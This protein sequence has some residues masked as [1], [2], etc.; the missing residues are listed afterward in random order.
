[1]S[2][3][4]VRVLIAGVTAVLLVAAAGSARAATV[5]WD[6]GTSDILTI[7]DGASQGGAGTWNTT[8]L[9]W[10]KAAAP[11]V[12]WVNANNDTAVFGGTA[13]T[14]TLA[15]PIAVGGVAFNV[16][17]YTISGDTLTFG[18]AGTIATNAD[19]TISSAIAGAVAIAKTGAGTLTLSG[20]NTFSGQLSVQGGTLAVGTIN[21]AGAAGTLGNSALP[22]ILGNTGGQTGAL[23][24][25]G[26][27]VSSSKN[28]TMATGGTG[29]FD[30]DNS[31]TNLTLTGTIDG[32][33]G[34]K[35]TGAG[36]LILS[37]TNS[38][39]GATSIAAGMLTINNSSTFTNTS[40]ITLNGTGRLNV[41]VAS[42][43]LAKVA[44]GGGVPAGTFLRYSQPQTSGGTGPG[45]ILGTVELNVTNVNPNYTLDFGDGGTLTNLGAYTYN[46]P[47][48]VSGN[49]F[50]VAGANIFTGGTAMTVSTSTAGLKTLTLTGTNTGANTIGGVISNGSGTLGVAKTGVGTWVLSGTNTYT[51]AT[52]ISTGTLT[53]SN[54]STFTNTSQIALSGTGRLDVNVANQTLAK[55]VT[56]GGVPA[57]TFLRYSQTQTTGNTGPGTIL[58]TVELNVNNVN[59]NYTLD[60][61]T[62]G[63]LT[64]LGAYTYTSPISLSGNASIDSSTAVFT[65]SVGGISASSAGAKTLALTGSNTSANAISS[66]IFNGG[67]TIGVTKSGAGTWILSGANTYTGP[68]N[69]N[70][71]TLTISNAATFT[72]TS[73][74]ALSGTGRLDVGV[75]NQSL[76][77]LVTGGGVPAGASLRYSQ[78]QTTGG[79]GPGTILGTVELNANNVNPNYTL[80]FGAGSTLTCVVTASYTSPITLS[81]NA[82]IDA[83]A[84][85][86]LGTG[87]T[88]SSSTPGA[89]TLTL[90]GSNTGA[91][92]VG[93]V[94]SNGS[95][96]LAV[97]KTGAGSWLLSGANTYTGATIITAGALRTTDGV[98]LPAN[99]P[100]ILNGGVLET[101]G[102][103]ARTTGTG[104]NQIQ[105][106]A[107]GGFSAYGGPLTV[108]LN[109]GT[110]K[111]DWSA[112]MAAGGLNAETLIFGSTATDNVV[113]VPNDL[114]LKGDRTIT[115][116]DNAGATADY[117][118]FSGVLANGDSNPRNLT[119]GGTGTLVL[120]G[121]N[122]Y[123]GSTTIDAGVLTA[124]VL[125]N[126]G[127]VGN[128]GQSGNAAG[129][130]LIGNGAT[131]RYAGAATSTDRLFTINGTAAGHRATI[132]ASGAGP[133]SFT[134][135]GSLEYGTPNQSRT[136]VLA[137]TNTG[138]NTFTPLIT[139][140]GS[141][142]TS[143]TK[144]GTGTWIL[145]VANTYT[146][147]TTISGGTLLVSSLANA[148]SNSNIGAYP[149]A[150]ATGLV[151]GGGTL[152]YTGGTVT[153]NRGFT[154]NAAASTIDV[155]AAGTALTLGACAL[156]AYQFNVTGGSG[157]SLA[158]G[159]VTLT[160]AATLNPTTANLTVASITGAYNLTL[161][162]T[163]AGSTVSGAIT[164]GTAAITKNDAGIWT[165]SGANTYTGVTT[166]S[167]GTLSVASLADAGSASSIG[168]YG[169]AGAAGLVL[170]GGTLKYTGGSATSNRGFTLNTAASTIDVNAVDT[171]LTLG[172]CSLGAFQLN[173]TGGSGS[174]LALGAVTLTGA[175]TLSPT[176]ANLTVG[177]VTGTYNL[178]LRGTSA[179]STVSGAI[180]TGTGTLIKN[181][182]GTWI[183]SGANTYT[184]VTTVSAGTLSV[185]SLG[186]AG[187]AS[188]IGSYGTAGAAG[189]VLGGGTLKYTGS[190]ATI[191]RGFTLNTAAST[192]DVNGADTLLTLGACSLGAFQLNVTGGSGSS[193]A[194]G[195]TTVTGNAAFAP[196]VP[197]VLASLAGSNQTVTFG[198][199]STT[200]VTDAVTFSDS[201]TITSNGTLS[202]STVNITATAAK[203][204]ALR[205]AGTAS[206]SGWIG[207]DGAN[208]LAI[209]KSDPGTWTLAGANAYTG[210][211]TI[212]EGT[213]KIENNTAL[214]STAGGVTV[215]GGAALALQNDIAVDAEALTLNGTG[216]ASGGALR[217]I[218]G[219]NTY[220][221]AITLGSAARINSD[222]GT[223]TLDVAF[224]NAI[225]GTQDL[226]F[227]GA[228]NIA[229]ADPVATG[230]GT[231]TKDGAGTLTL[232]GNN[233]YTGTTTVTAG[234]LMLAPA[235]GSALLAT[236]TVQNNDTLEIAAPEQ[237]A[238]K[239]SGTGITLVDAGMSLTADSIVQ[240]TLT[241]GAGASVTIRATPAA[242]GSANA[243]PEPGTWALIGIGL[244]SLLALGRRRGTESLVGAGILLWIAAR[245]WPP[246]WRARRTPCD[247]G[248]PRRR[249]R[250]GRRA[251]GM[252]GQPVRGTIGPVAETMNFVAHSG[253]TGFFLR[254]QSKDRATDERSPVAPTTPAGCVLRPPAESACG[255]WFRPGADSLRQRGPVPGLRAGEKRH[256]ERPSTRV[257]SPG[258]EVRVRSYAALTSESPASPDRSAQFMQ[259]RPRQRAAGQAG[260][261]SPDCPRPPDV[262]NHPLPPRDEPWRQESEP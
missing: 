67:G 15:V 6:G 201:A 160:G 25:T 219:N 190:T 3:F 176:T 251:G 9:N 41:N 235:F 21:N 111:I 186:D 26:A 20:A 130:L 205:G 49:A 127:A 74:I 139:D 42:Q 94:I 60:L 79:T 233:T 261:A 131:L 113:T 72:N 204:L 225:A 210:A 119:K 182:A 241:I 207:Q 68:T 80:D 46:S 138:D 37:G 262:G 14:V 167:A 226:T 62:G 231:L 28:F 5:Y 56:G 120:S 246:S 208:A 239:I 123:S 179:G 52:N 255:S 253:L 222:G 103:F 133:M 82:S 122:T 117:A 55:L 70:A 104:S 249:C 109:G 157:S 260:W 244:L 134:N 189:L 256:F 177:S 16:A 11:H 180:T 66:V 162:G 236:A 234:T 146:G 194:L 76:A 147:A 85:I 132:D 22:V 199:T 242:A 57:G 171:A 59:P 257:R 78:P 158:L 23:Q 187:F 216:I 81:G 129:N 4:R 227:G 29:A 203:T 173:V 166:V 170:G 250:D 63:T 148:G 1:M 247:P 124:T 24:Y 142:A 118:V 54:A 181:D 92:T 8:I 44:A 259:W 163:S 88:V 185:S 98:G 174:S 47:I 36:T 13:G 213:L 90:T 53:V 220:A 91:N 35:K 73:Q 30:V 211:T 12:A 215:A 126:G 27:T 45:T 43:S 240:N 238:G 156:G 145:P 48:T 184:G 114:D 214:G 195:A 108:H 87:I 137:G 84:A 39:G 71:G 136:L 58:G 61:G 151:L 230:A 97:T 221:G 202:L 51:G 161:R 183:L 19:A 197:L 86:L 178:T 128:I 96:T 143:L 196:S 93:G 172:A 224:G 50:I 152:K 141:G 89:K 154:L 153:V 110:A 33:G 2:R 121:V 198:G 107:G 200:T 106:T 64:N 32:G 248:K 212:N 209:T 217:N 159:A 75:A 31:T 105:W 164:T 38:Y 193:L 149:V 99:S 169:T 188:N 125:S 7:G 228:G 232:T 191:N 245:P 252:A 17:G 175:A 135:T 229:V 100:L 115:V 168:S 192:I 40:Q 83:S 243:V 18:A 95:G 77:K 65:V 237:L 206:V 101:A 116:I 140:N 144:T 155:N 254:M 223:L 165:L 69:V 218:S 10:D 150:G 34:L 258:E 102:T 112:S